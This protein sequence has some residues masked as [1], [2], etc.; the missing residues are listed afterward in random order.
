[1]CEWSMQVQ[2]PGVPAG[3]MGLAWAASE[4]AESLGLPSPPLPL[5]RAPWV[6]AYTC[7]P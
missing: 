7:L 6:P 2:V 3:P 5:A 1:M 4:V